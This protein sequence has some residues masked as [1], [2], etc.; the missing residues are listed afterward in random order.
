MYYCSHLSPHQGC[1]YIIIEET[2]TI[3][4][5]LQSVCPKPK[6]YPQKWTIPSMF[7]CKI[8]L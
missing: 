8:I 4:S 6:S 5:L 1:F 2:W 3:E 7:Q